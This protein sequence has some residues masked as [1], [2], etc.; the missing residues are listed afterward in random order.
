MP[1]ATKPKRP[2]YTSL[3]TLWRR[4]NQNKDLCRR[5]LKGENNKRLAINQANTLIHELSMLEWAG[6]W[7][8]VHS[9][10]GAICGDVQNHNE[11]F[12][13]TLT[14]T[15]TL[16][17]RSHYLVLKLNWKP[18]WVLLHSSLIVGG[19]I[20]SIAPL[21]AAVLTI[22]NVSRSPLTSALPKQD[23]IHGISFW[24]QSAPKQQH[25]GPVGPSFM[26]YLDSPRRVNYNNQPGRDKRMDDTFC[27][28]VP[29]FSDVAQVLQG[30][31]WNELEL[32]T[33][34]VEEARLMLPSRAASEE[35]VLHRG[36]LS[37]FSSVLVLQDFE[38]DWN[39]KSK[40]VW[41]GYID[42]YKWVASS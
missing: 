8:S 35:N 16:S 22:A 21:A 33:S 42:A 10:G 24:F 6:T 18:C 17:R 41:S 31:P 3:C 5:W 13:L 28:Q 39:F 26:T 32:H 37:R 30:R 40:W 14:L 11:V 15:L 12:S 34:V 38:A 23:W 9:S 29:R 4:Q 20:T 25:S 27:F 36:G 2:R 19:A 7:R 1:D